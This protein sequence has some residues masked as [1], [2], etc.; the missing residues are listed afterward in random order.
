MTS[1]FQILRFLPLFP[2][3]PFFFPFFLFSLRSFL[4]AQLGEVVHAL[5]DDLDVISTKYDKLHLRL[6]TKK[7]TAILFQTT[8]KDRSLRNDVFPPIRLGGDIIPLGF[9]TKYL[10]VHL[11]SRL[12]FVEQV[13]S[14][15][16]KLGR[17]SQN[18][19]RIRC[20]LPRR[21][22]QEI[23]SVFVTLFLDYCSPVW[24]SC[25]ATSY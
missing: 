15:Q 3:T 2:F 24:G 17:S 23:Y 16:K 4:C 21:G 7:S 19:K 20:N 18:F 22:S 11:D 6:N 9:R 13:Q 5:N 10:G 8:G 1:N 25:A 12:S 14:V